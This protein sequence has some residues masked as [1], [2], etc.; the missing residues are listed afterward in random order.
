VRLPTMCASAVAFAVVPRTR[1]TLG[2]VSGAL[3]A[4]PESCTR[5]APLPDCWAGAP[6]TQRMQVATTDGVASG[7]KAMP[8]F[9]TSS[10][11]CCRRGCSQDPLRRIRHHCTRMALAPRP[12]GLPLG[13][14]PI[15]DTLISLVLGALLLQGS[16]GIARHDSRL[17]CPGFAACL[18]DKSPACCSVYCLALHSGLHPGMAPWFLVAICLS[19]WMS[20]IVARLI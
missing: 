18:L 13:T 9:P 20:A 5:N 16:A 17:L 14:L 4:A 3:F 11:A 6:R 15:P 2:C 10:I 19:H 7:H 1:A 12:L 8:T